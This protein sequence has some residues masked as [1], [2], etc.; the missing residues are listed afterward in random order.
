[1]EGYPADGAV[2]VPID[3]VP[4]YSTDAAWLGWDET[5]L[6]GGTLT[7]RD[8]N[9]TEVPIDIRDPHPSTLTLAPDAELE[10]NAR[11]SLEL[12]AAGPGNEPTSAIVEFETGTARAAAPE[13]PSAFLQHYEFLDYQQDSCSMARRGTCLAFAEGLTI[14]G[15]YTDADGLPWSTYNDYLWTQPVFVDLTGIEQGT[16]FDCVELR[17]RAAN[18]TLSE[19]TTVCGSDGPY[20]DLDGKALKRNARAVCTPEG[21]SF[22][23]RLVTDPAPAEPEAASAE[24]GGGGCSVTSSGRGVNTLTPWL[25][26][27]AAMRL[28]RGRN[29]AAKRRTGPSSFR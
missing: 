17:T 1:L 3:V 25:M 23:G 24:G 27:L 11:Y 29:L 20:F 26:L 8:A 22:K 21:I 9:G 18:G 19:P 13:P 14:V 16:P 28:I 6:Q 10:P 4:F 5:G 2:D 15:T 7:L 12:S